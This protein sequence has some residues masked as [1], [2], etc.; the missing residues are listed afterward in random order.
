[1]DHLALLY[2]SVTFALVRDALAH[3]GPADPSHLSLLDCANLMLPSDFNTFPT[4]SAVG[5]LG[6][7]P[8]Y[9][10]APR[11][12]GEP[13]LRPYA[14][15]HTLE[16]SGTTG[17]SPTE[18][19]SGRTLAV[20]LRPPEV[21]PYVLGQELPRT[22]ASLGSLAILGVALAV[23]GTVLSS[24]AGGSAQ[25]GIKSGRHRPSIQKRPTTPAARH[26]TR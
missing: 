18:S 16:G 21:Q 3:D 13:A 22:G 24:L 23:I 5:I 26:G 19:E 15:T 6:V 17:T 4:D 25:E 8:P 20:P 1:M 12:A 10:F 9:L 14:S 11:V 7:I 2:D